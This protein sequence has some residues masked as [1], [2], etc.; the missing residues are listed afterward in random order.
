MFHSF[1]ISDCVQ[2]YTKLSPDDDEFTPEDC[3]TWNNYL[4]L[5]IDLEVR[6][7][8]LVPCSTFV[9]GEQ[10]HLWLSFMLFL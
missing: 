4:S 8:V 10:C 2:T 6:F 5:V 1:N 7:G 9:D 3:Q